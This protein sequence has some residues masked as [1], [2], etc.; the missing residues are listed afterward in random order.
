MASITT[1]IRS[2]KTKKYALAGVVAGIG[3]LL[4]IKKGRRSLG[5]IAKFAA[6]GAVVGGAGSVALQKAGA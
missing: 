6:V 1:L 5:R 3:Y 4:F 2:E